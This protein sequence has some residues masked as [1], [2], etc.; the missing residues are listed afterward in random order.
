MRLV[1]VW[2]FVVLGFVQRCYVLAVTRYPSRGR[3]RTAGGEGCWHEDQYTEQIEQEARHVAGWLWGPALLVPIACALWADDTDKWKQWLAGLLIN[4]CP[5]CNIA[6]TALLL[7]TKC[8]VMREHVMAIVDEAVELDA[9]DAPEEALDSPAAGSGGGGVLQRLGL[10]KVELAR[11]SMIWTKVL[12]VQMLVCLALLA[13]SVTTLL[14]RS[15]HSLLFETPLGEANNELMRSFLQAGPVLWAL[16]VSF[17]TVVRLNTFLRTV[18]ERISRESRFSLKLRCHFAQ[19]YERLGM[20][21]SVPVLGELTES[22]L[23]S[24]IFGFLGLI[25]FVLSFP[26][27]MAGVFNVEL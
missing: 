20:W 21:L 9:A 12:G 17:R 16:V 11:L 5:L 19:E 3:D 2:V 14:H 15:G 7:G 8:V 10:A 26:K 22:N 24:A 6:A 25:S 23:W 18:P 27:Q 13:N 1:C 4:L